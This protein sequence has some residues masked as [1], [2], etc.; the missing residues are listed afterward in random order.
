MIQRN[1]SAIEQY[2]E[3]PRVSQITVAVLTVLAF[4][5]R[6]AKLNH[7]DQVVY[8]FP[9]RFLVTQETKFSGATASMR[10]ISASSPHIIC[11][12]ST[13][14]MS[15]LHL[16]NCCS[17]LPDGLSALREISNSQTLVTVT[18]PTTSRIGGC[19]HCRPYWAASRFLLYTISCRRVDTPLLLLLSL[20]S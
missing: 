13:T 17:L 7:P 6:F 20:L 4:I 3:T 14:L 15:I 16:R 19:V 10:F 18:R 12:A 5:V 1:R 9:L 2:M 11:V 8:V